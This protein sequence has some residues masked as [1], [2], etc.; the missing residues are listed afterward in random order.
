MTEE[1]VGKIARVCHETNR[2]YCETLGDYSQQ[3]WYLSPPWQQE[4]AVNGV[5]FHLK[6]PGSPP[7]ASHNSWLKEK[8]DTGWKLGPTKNPDKKEHPC[9]VPYDELP[10]EQKKK[11]KLFIAVVEALR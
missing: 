9:I 10:E 3:M 4:S 11:D 6:N 7:S 5:K 2:A 1:Q 8:L